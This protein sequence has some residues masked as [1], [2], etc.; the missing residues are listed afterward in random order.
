MPHRSRSREDD[1]SFAGMG[2]AIIQMRERRGL[3]RDELAEKI[4]AGPHVLERIESGQTNADW[5]TLRVVAH[6]LC[7]PLYALIELAEEQAPGEGGKEW[8]RRTR[9]VEREREEEVAQR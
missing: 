3:D 2:K 8:R 9:E 5:A 1:A 6:A 7:V 4:E